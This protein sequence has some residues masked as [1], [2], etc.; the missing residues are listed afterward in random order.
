MLAYRCAG[1]G[2][3]L[4]WCWSGAGEGSGSSVLFW[5]R[6]QICIGGGVGMGGRG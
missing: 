2:L 3:V 6:G 1:V 4:G 5:V